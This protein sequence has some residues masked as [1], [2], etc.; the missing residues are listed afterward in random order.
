MEQ[1]TFHQEISE[2]PSDGAAYWIHA[3]DQVRLRIAAWGVEAATKGTV[4]LFPGRTEYIEK[5]GRTAEQLAKRGYASF[6][7]DWRG[8]GLADRLTENPITGH[9]IRYS[10]YQKDVAAMLKAAN[11]LDLPKP[12]F[13]LG[14]SMG[15]SIGLRALMQ[16]LPV[17]ACAFTAPLWGIPLSPIQRMMAWPMTWAAQAIG[18]GHIFAPGNKPQETQCYVLN[19]EFQ[20]N[21]LTNDPDMFQYMINQAKTLPDHQI[22]APSMGWVF[23]ALKECRNL[24]KMPSPDVPCIVFYGDQ[25]VVV[26]I[27]AIKDRMARWPGGTLELLPNAKHDPLSETPKTRDNVLNKACK[28]FSQAEVKL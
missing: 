26:D 19:V 2:G 5:L 3:D 21:R 27:L 7:I 12:W 20:D 16:G 10:D 6:A 14:H 9:V 8:Q 1:A 4:L 13:L 18:K 24:S 25:D 17:S 15:A 28:L 23:E 11:E 22:G